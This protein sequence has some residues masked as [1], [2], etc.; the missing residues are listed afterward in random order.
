MSRAKPFQSSHEIF[1][2]YIPGYE[3]G[4]DESSADYPSPPDDPHATVLDLLSRF[5][6]DLASLELRPAK[7]RTRRKS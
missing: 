7:R 6:E 4:R 2:T 5:R 1:A 3:N